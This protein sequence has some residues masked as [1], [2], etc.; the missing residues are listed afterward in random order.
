VAQSGSAASSSSLSPF[1]F[2]WM[3]PKNCHEIPAKSY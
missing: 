3:R 2:T 1:S